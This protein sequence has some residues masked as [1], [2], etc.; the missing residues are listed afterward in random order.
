M[1]ILLVDDHKLIRDAI[2][3]YMDSDDEFDVVD[4]AGNGQEAL[5]LLKTVEVDVV[6]L[7]I[8][9]PVMDGIVCAQE[10][11]N[12]YPDIKV[13]ALSMMNDNQF[14]KQ[15]LA[16]GALGYILKNSGEE[17]IKKALRKVNDGETYY[18]AEVAETV[19]QNMMKGGIKRSNKLVVDLPRT[20]RE[21]EVLHLI[22]KEYTNQEMA[23]ELFISPRTVDAHKRNLLEKTGSKNIAG[24]VLYAI[25]KNL[26][27]D[28]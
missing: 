6:M 1:K 12:A 9:M 14:I 25:E 8:S 21:E 4:E 19:M 11:R 3:S 24:L 26:F 2:K 13:L 17:E 5:I 18:S 10:I 7:D 16:A 15:M 22:I 27:E 28:L 20:S 23:D